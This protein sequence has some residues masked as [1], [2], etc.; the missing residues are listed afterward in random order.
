MRLHRGAWPHYSPLDARY[1]PRVLH[2]SAFDSWKE[3]LP[4]IMQGYSSDD[5]WNL[6][7]SG[8]FWKALPDKGFGQK[9][10]E[11]KG[12][13]RSKQRLTVT[14][15]VN[16]AGKSESKP[17]VLWR[18]E[19]PRCF[20]GIK[21]SELP[22]EYYSQAKAWMS[23]DILHKILSNI[24][25]KLKSEGRSVI[26]FMDNAG[27]HPPD[28]KEKYSNI[29]VVYLPANTTSMLQPLDLGIIRNFKVHYRKLLMTFIL[30][31]IEKCSSASEVLQS[32]N[33]LHAIRWVADAWKS[34]SEITIKKCFRKAGMLAHDFSVVS[35]F[36]SPETDP[37]SDIV[38]VFITLGLLD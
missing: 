18:S 24:D 27:C 32:V 2:F 1:A 35:P 38:I 12:G 19:N 21:K 25:K 30:A 17:I 5:I 6:D 10:K 9:V 34:V 16:G 8:V 26:L 33:V 37:F 4:E 28:L 20:K 3:R 15:I 23:G 14:F 36:I 29:K 7:E 13:K 22:V 11:C 31:K